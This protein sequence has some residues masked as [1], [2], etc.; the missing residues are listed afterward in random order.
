[1]VGRG[2][3]LFLPMG[4]SKPIRIQGAWVVTDAQVNG[5]VVRDPAELRAL[6]SMKL[7]FKGDT[8]INS[9][10]RD[11]VSKFQLDGG[12]T[13]LKRQI[14]AEARKVGLNGAIASSAKG[15]QL[16]QT[17]ARRVCRSVKR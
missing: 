3:G 12:K 5:E 17:V 2:D 11:T 15:E 4:A 1:M 6:Q 9:N 8:V 7:T 10:A 14:L 16:I 13:P